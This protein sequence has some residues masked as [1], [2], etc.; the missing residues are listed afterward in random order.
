MF[1]TNRRKYL[2]WM[3]TSIGATSLVLLLFFAS[4]NIALNSHESFAAAV[5]AATIS[6]CI[7]ALLIS[8]EAA[9]YQAE[10]IGAVDGGHAVLFL[11]AVVFFVVG[12]IVFL[13]GIGVQVYASFLIAGIFSVLVYMRVRREILKRP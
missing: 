5:F 11:L 10:D 9:L 8:R 12:F 1:S 2:D 13:Y 3:L 4:K 6:L 7:G